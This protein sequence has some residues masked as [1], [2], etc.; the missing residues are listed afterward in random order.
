M[1]RLRTYQEAALAR[2]L[3]FEMGDGLY[4]LDTK[5]LPRN[6]LPHWLIW[7]TLGGELRKLISPAKDHESI[8]FIQAML[9]WR[10]TIKLDDETLVIAGILDI[11]IIFYS[12][13]ERTCNLDCSL[14]TR[15][16]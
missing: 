9:R 8:G 6:S 13:R 11:D 16:A 5:H 1:G 10:D 12:F 2:R 3:L 15:K 4:E 14:G 7:G